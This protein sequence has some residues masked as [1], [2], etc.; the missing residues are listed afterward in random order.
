MKE[1]YQ[2]KKN[3]KIKKIKKRNWKIESPWAQNSNQRDRSLLKKSTFSMLTISSVPLDYSSDKKQFWPGACGFLVATS[4]I[5]FSPTRTITWITKRLTFIQPW[6]KPCRIYQQQSVNRLSNTSR[7]MDMFLC[8][9]K[10]CSI[11]NNCNVAL[12][13]DMF[14]QLNSAI[15]QLYI[16]Q[17]SLIIQ[18]IQI[19]IWQRIFQKGCILSIWKRST[20]GR[21]LV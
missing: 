9:L 6:Y 14:L 17:I 16:E 15:I 8:F 10:N 1:K 3:C 5:P 20:G 4:K 2:Q 7:L 13:L 12:K 11:K 21:F 18:N 19:E